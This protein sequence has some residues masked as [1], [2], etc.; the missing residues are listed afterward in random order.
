MTRDVV[1]VCR[2]GLVQL[3]VVWCLPFIWEDSPF[4]QA[5][6]R[7]VKL[8]PPTRSSAKSLSRR[9]LIFGVKGAETDEWAV[10]ESMLRVL[11]EFLSWNDDG[12]LSGYDHKEDWL[13]WRCLS[14]FFLVTLFQLSRVGDSSSST[15]ANRSVWVLVYECKFEY[16][17]EYESHEHIK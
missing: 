14:F 3:F 9:L 13:R 17:N 6:Q 11:D 5:P 12:R 2:F 7:K 16:E 4:K 8:P 15:S 1:H 10:E